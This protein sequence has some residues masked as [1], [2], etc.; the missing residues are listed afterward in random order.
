MCVCVAWCVIEGVEKSYSGGDDDVGFPHK[1]DESHASY[2]NPSMSI[3]L[4]GGL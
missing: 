3:S 2:R 1:A 4:Y